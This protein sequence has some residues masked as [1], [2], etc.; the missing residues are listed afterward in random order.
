[1]NITAAGLVQGPIDKRVQSHSE[2]RT[3]PLEEGLS[4]LIAVVIGYG[5][6]ECLAPEYLG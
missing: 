2:E 6:N 1:M 3:Y 5:R 4:R